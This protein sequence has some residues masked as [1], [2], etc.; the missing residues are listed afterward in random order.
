MQGVAG[1]VQ[2][3]GLAGLASLQASW[4]CTTTWLCVALPLGCQLTQQMAA[5]MTHKSMQLLAGMSGW[6]SLRTSQC[7]VHL[8]HCRKQ[9]LATPA[10]PARL[11]L[12]KYSSIQAA[13]KLSTWLMLRSTMPAALAVSMRTAKCAV[14]LQD[15]HMHVQ[16]GVQLTRCVGCH[17]SH[18]PRS[19]L[20]IDHPAAATGQ[21]ARACAAHARVGFCP[22]L[23]S[24]T[25]AGSA[26]VRC[27]HRS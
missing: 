10:R 16:P 25:A 4:V 27:T 24:S 12:V 17:G 23:H 11:T 14:S 8:V 26:S 5:G 1:R 21:A 6:A 19:S 7:L 13:L 9:T 3:R 18:L 2:G 15:G 20:S 22:G